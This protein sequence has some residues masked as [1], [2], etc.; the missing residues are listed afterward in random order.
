MASKAMFSKL[1]IGTISVI[2]AVPINALLFNLLFK[3]NI[4]EVS[5]ENKSGFVVES[6]E[7]QLCNEKQQFK[8]LEPEK[9]ISVKFDVHGDCHYSVKVSLGINRFLSLEFGYVTSGSH[10]NDSIVIEED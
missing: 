5:F 1:F 9:K 7:V 2:L 10:F 4:A 8:M 6:I 3:P